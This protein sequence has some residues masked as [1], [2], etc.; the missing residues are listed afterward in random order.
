MILKDLQA[1]YKFS[2]SSC[3]T[4]C[5]TQHRNG[6]IM[7]TL[8]EHLYLRGKRGIFQ[9]RR[10]IPKDLHHLYPQHKREVVVSL[11]T[12]DLRLAKERLHAE[13]AKVDAEFAKRRNSFKQTWSPPARQQVTDL[14]PQQLDDLAQTWTHSVLRADQ[15]ER[16]AG[17]SEAEFEELDVELDTQRKDLGRLLARGCVDPI[18]PAMYSVMHILGYDTKFDAATEH[19][20]AM[21]LLEAVVCWRRPNFDHPRRLN[22]DQG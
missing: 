12:S 4:R 8:P 2:G 21:R 19:K 7:Q 11:G 22:F 17:L 20:V 5:Y 1:R 15:N 13:E 16:S 18:V 6:N 9:F 10:R 14:T 3:Y